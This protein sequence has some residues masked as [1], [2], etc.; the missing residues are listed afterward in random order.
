ME[1]RYMID[2]QGRQVPVEH[3]SDLDKLR[4]QTVKSIASKAL[5]QRDASLSAIVN[6]RPQG[7]EMRS[8]IDHPWAV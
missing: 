3:V 6:A 8:P 5:A 4:D 2:S 1:Q 7:A